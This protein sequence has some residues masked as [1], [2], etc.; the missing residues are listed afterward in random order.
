VHFFIEELRD[1]VDLVV[2][3]ADLVAGAKLIENDRLRNAEIDTL[4]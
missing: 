2:D 4:R 1:V 3:L